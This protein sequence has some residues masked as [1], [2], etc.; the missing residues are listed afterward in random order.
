MGIVGDNPVATPDK[1]LLGRSAVAQHVAADLREV[2]ASAGYVYALTGPWGSGKTSLINMVRS[3]LQ[4]EP[5]ITVVDFNPWLFSGTTQLVDAFFQE[6]AAQLRLKDDRWQK[7]ASDVEAYGDLLSPLSA[8]PFIGAWVE[9]ARSSVTA[10]KEFQERRRGSVVDRRGRLACALQAVPGPLVVVIDDIDRLETAE[11]RDIFRLVRLTGSFPN[12]VYLLAF[13]RER[14]ANALTETGLDGQAYLEKIVQLAVDI[15]AVPRQVLL[16]LLTSALDEAVNSLDVPERFDAG[17]WPDVLA[18]VILPLVASMRDVRRYAGAARTTV[19]AV[20]GRVELSD[21]LALEAL[22]V[23]LPSAFKVLLQAREGLTTTRSGFAAT[24][25]DDERLREQVT[26]F[27]SS[28]PDHEAVLQAVVA[29]LFPAGLRHLANNSYGSD[30]LSRWLRDR[31]VAHPDVFALYLERVPSANLIA[32]GNAE[33]AFAVLANPEELE[34]ELARHS[35]EA[36]EDIIASLEVYE[37]DFPPEAAVPASVVLLNLAPRLPE[38]QRG[39]FDL[40]D[41]QL[42]V[43][44]VVLRLLR[45][46]PSKEEVREAVVQI[47]AQLT[48]LSARLT[49]VR[50]VTP[51]ESEPLVHEADGIALRTELVQAIRATPASELAQERDLLKLLLAP[52]HLAVG[53]TI[54]VSPEDQSLS[55]ALLLAAKTQMRSQVMGTR[56]VGR[57]YRLSWTLL[58]ELFEGEDNIRRAAQDVE[59]EAQR[60]PSP[61]VR[62]LIALVNQYLAGWRPDD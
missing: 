17:R 10:V 55:K 40:G 6:L 53:D 43:A 59:A 19:R 34:V 27:V 23:F 12:V 11:I 37:D 46:L 29:R 32:F 26:N 13:D 28:E 2:D 25:T 62:D 16:H 57:A 30:W 39:M 50:L 9:R 35:L 4:N 58:E 60:D 15:P 3:E 22:R 18:E 54:K 38:R 56:S 41:S 7:I 31:R 5:A 20:S 45:R 48:S 47:L 49:V 14:V 61:E 36:L 24:T 8:V 44:R 1:D 33:A 52:R 21:V 51:S 42:V